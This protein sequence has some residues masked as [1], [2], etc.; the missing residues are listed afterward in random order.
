M[1]IL[2]WI[3]QHKVGILATI[4]FHLVLITLFL[5]LQLNSIKPKKETQVFI[6]FTLPEDLQKE[7]KQK[8]EEVKKLNSSDFIN[9]MQK[10]YLGHNIA[11]NE[12]DESKKSIDKMVS[13]IKSELN[14]NDQRPIDKPEDHVTLKQIDTKEVNSINK[15]GYTTNAKGE[16]TFYK[17]STTISYFLEGRTEVYIPVPVYKCQGSGKVALEIEVD[18]SGFVITATINKKESQ[19]TDECLI[20]AAIKAALTT[21]FNAKVTASSRQA[22][23]ISYIFIAQ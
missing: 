2:D 16:R 14:I 19:I 18:Q 11:V 5:A 6:D 4:L 10:E 20:E 13:D 1:D 8:Q 9:K 22:G 7:I 12:A 3:E 23:R 15:P 17:G 21:R